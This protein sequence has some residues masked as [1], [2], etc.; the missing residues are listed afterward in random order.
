MVQ[1]NSLTSPKE[2]VIVIGGPTCVG[3]SEYAVDVAL[4]YGGEVVSADSVQI[5]RGLD[6]GSGKITTEEMRG[7][8]HHMLDIVDPSENNF[9]VA[10]YI[11]RAKHTITDIIQRGKLPIIVG[12]TGFYINALLHG[13]NCGGSGPNYKLR[14]RLQALQVKHKNNYL[15]DKLV[16]I[17]P[18]TTVHENDLVRIIRQLELLLSPHCDSDDSTAVYCDA[19]DAVLVIMDA[20]REKLDERAA[21]RIEEMFAAGLMKEV[22]GLRDYFGNRCMDSVG[23]RE[24][25][26]GIT[27]G[28]S[29][30]KIKEDMKISYHRLI[31]KQQTFFRWL[32]WKNKV[33]LYNWERTTADA[34]IDKFVRSGQNG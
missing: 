34:Y 13:Y 5:Y 32:Q 28:R 17:T 10:M 6:I 4:K 1:T 33:S 3:K 21:R 23:Y 11:E 26:D 15:Y 12:G 30:D 31:K 22:E 14:R 20:D 24:V 2:R 8:P 27:Y 19:Y 7:V 16:K 29:E 18:W 25:A 9:S